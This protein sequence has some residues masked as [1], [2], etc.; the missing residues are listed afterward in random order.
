MAVSR[1]A[2]D[3]MCCMNLE[4]NACYRALLSTDNN[5]IDKALKWLDEHLYDHDLHN[6]IVKEFF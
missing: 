4:E 3:I 2:Y 1:I 6:I 5:S